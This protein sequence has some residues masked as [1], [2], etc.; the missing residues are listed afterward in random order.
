MTPELN[1]P[2][3]SIKFHDFLIEHAHKG[4]AV[5]MHKN[6]N[7]HFDL[8]KKY[9]FKIEKIMKTYIDSDLNDKIDNF[10]INKGCLFS[11]II[12]AKKLL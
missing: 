9:N 10:K 6:L 8:L 3:K 12:Q 2:F 4:Y 5:W 1:K 7:D 11:N